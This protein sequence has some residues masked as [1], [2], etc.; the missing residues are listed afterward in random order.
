M[1]DLNKHV[2]Q[3]IRKERCSQDISAESV[4]RAA[5][6]GSN[7]PISRIENYTGIPSVGKL[8][9]IAQCLGLEPGDLLPTLAEMDAAL[10]QNRAKPGYGNR[11]ISK[12]VAD[13]IRALYASG[14]FTY[15]EMAKEFPQVGE[16]QIQKICTGVCWT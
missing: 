1:L 4:C 9:R 6:Y 12:E 15:P 2:G 7:A 8:C 16:S 3:A 10:G 14:L 11:K 13:E 5:G